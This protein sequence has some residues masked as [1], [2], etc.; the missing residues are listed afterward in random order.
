MSIEYTPPR[1]PHRRAKAWVIEAFE[2]GTD[3]LVGTYEV[4][5]PAWMDPRKPWTEAHQMLIGR[6]SR[7]TPWP[8]GL[9]VRLTIE[10]KP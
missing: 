10:E 8:R 4:S 1:E 2:Q 6:L 5:L 9:K 3:R 7:S